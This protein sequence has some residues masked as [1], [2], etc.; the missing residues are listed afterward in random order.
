MVFCQGAASAARPS[1][2]KNAKCYGENLGG[3]RVAAGRQGIPGEVERED[4]GTLFGLMRKTMPSMIRELSTRQYWT[5]WHTC[6]GKW[7]SA[8]EGT[9]REMASGRDRTR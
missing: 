3:G 8:G 6:S 2:R 4:G 1:T 5:L 7:I 9:G